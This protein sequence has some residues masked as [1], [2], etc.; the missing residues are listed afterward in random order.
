MRISSRYF[1]SFVF[2]AFMYASC[3]SGATPTS[4]VENGFDN[5][6]GNCAREIED[7]LDR[8]ASVAVV[9]FESH[10]PE[11]SNDI[12]EEFMGYLIR[13]GKLTVTDRAR[14]D[15]LFTE[16]N[17]S[18][19]GNIDDETALRIGKMV[20]AQFVITGSL[21]D[22]GSTY[23]LRVTAIH[24]ETAVRKAFSS[25]DIARVDTGKR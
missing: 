24:T 19:S 17:L 18:M 1:V 23:R 3:V 21:T 2:I 8:G 14:L 4:T 16:L 20:G 22:R 13:S 11:L 12:M 25:A 10:S 5:A 6:V 7:A 15:L 9:G